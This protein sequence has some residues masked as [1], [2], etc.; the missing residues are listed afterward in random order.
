MIILHIRKSQI[1]LISR[2]FRAVLCRWLVFNVL[3]CVRVSVCVC[4]CLSLCRD[5]Q[6][7]VWEEADALRSL[8]GTHRG[9]LRWPREVSGTRTGEKEEEIRPTSPEFIKVCD[10]IIKGSF[11]S[12][13]MGEFYSITDIKSQKKAPGSRTTLKCQSTVRWSCIIYCAAALH[14]CASFS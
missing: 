1:Q 4:V 13:A 6:N 5:N 12:P 14:R 2:Q 9:L 3:L 11:S 8:R 7:A 10:K